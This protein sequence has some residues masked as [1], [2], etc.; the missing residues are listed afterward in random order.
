MPPQLDFDALTAQHARHLHR[1]AR[2]V[3]HDRHE[4]EDAVQETL[5]AA[6][7]HWDQLRDPDRVRAWL[8]QICMRH[9]LRV[10]V[11]LARSEPGLP[12]FDLPA[13]PERREVGVRFDPDLERACS[14]LT[15]RQRA[16]VLLHQAMGYPL[17]ECA[18]LMGCRPGTART[19]L[20]RGVAA[21]R[22]SR[23]LTAA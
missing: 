4:A 6:W 21:L 8:T 16:A 20:Q 23:H 22:D 9:C 18:E 5:V 17:V 3:L 13:A 10:K 14:E 19:H 12:D 2:S 11:R 1:I 15:E 7:R